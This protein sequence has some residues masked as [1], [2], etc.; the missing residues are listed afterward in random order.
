MPR[1][2]LPSDV[3]PVTRLADGAVTSVSSSSAHLEVGMRVRGRFKRRERW[4]PGVVR[5]V[6]VAGGLLDNGGF[7]RWRQ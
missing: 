6:E 3:G 5:A 2:M 4:Y 7:R 1:A